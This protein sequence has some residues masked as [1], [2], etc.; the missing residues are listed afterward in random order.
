MIYWLVALTLISSQ[1]SLA[2]VRKGLSF[3]L[4][5]GSVRRIK[6]NK[7]ITETRWIVPPHP[8]SIHQPLVLSSQRS[9]LGS[10]RRSESARA[11]PFLIENL[12]IPR[13]WPGCALET[14]AWFHYAGS[15][16]NRGEASEEHRGLLAKWKVHW[17][18]MLSV[19]RHLENMCRAQREKQKHNMCTW[20]THI[21]RCQGAERLSDNW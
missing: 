10:R 18:M 2:V 8:S 7:F 11:P 6:W 9:G 16:D 19:W 21:E 12:K 13:S 3:A 4:P 1:A 15:R 14:A 5:L 17:N 20:Q